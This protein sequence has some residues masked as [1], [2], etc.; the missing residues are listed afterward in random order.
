VRREAPLGWDVQRRRVGALLGSIGSALEWYDFTLY[1]YLA[2]VLAGL[3]FPSSDSLDGLL[4][5]YGVF[6]AGFLMRPLGAAFFGNLGDT[7]GRKAALTYSAVM[8]SIAPLG[9]RASRAR[10]RWP[11]LRG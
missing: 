7:R 2:P 6:A 9:S 4:A 5:A 3:F 1:V 11:G 8:M 10:P